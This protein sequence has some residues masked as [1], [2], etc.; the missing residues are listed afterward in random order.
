MNQIIAMGGGGFSMEPENL[1][2]EK[3]ILKQVNGKEK[4]KVCFLPTA[5]GDAQDHIDRFYQSFKTLCCEPS[6]LSLFE[7]PQAD[8]LDFIMDK[9]V[10]YVGGGNTKS[11]LAL[12]REWG[13]DIILK[14]AYHRGIIMAGLSAGALCWFEQSV[15]DSLGAHLAEINGLGWLEGSFCPHYD[16]ETNRR[17]V[18]HKLIL[19]GDA[20]DGLAADEGAACHFIDGKLVKTIGS[21]VGDLVYRVK[22]VDGKILEE[23][24]KM[25]YLS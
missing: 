17:P 22:K 15:T 21:R 7:P 16:A 9:D 10:I 19:D 23:P 1:L 14:E 6:H 11:M 5:S 8:L 2:L 25:D 12:W 13:L 18:F 20:S 24:F 3:Y 4:P